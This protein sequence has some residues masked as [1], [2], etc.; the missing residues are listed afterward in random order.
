M[1]YKEFEEKV[2]AW[3]EKYNYATKVIIGDFNTH[4]RVGTNE[5]LYVTAQVSN[6]Y[7]YALETNWNYFTEIEKHARA[8]LFDILV[9]FTKTP[10]ADRKDK[11]R[12]IIPLPGL[13]TTDGE[14]QYL[15]KNGSFFASR[16]DK[17]LRQTW[18]EEHLK[19]VPYEYRQFAIEFDEEG[20]D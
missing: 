16:R 7:M 15:T 6:M 11:K 9:E 1:R 14:Q 4:M 10:P 2:E 17:R 20:E 13:V 19:S 18:K 5:E 8:E 3:G 12:F